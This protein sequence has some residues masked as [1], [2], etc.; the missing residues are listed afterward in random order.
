MLRC[1]ER[2]N[3]ATKWAVSAAVF[4]VVAYLQSPLSSWWLVGAI[5]NAAVTKILKKIFKQRRPVLARLDDE[6]TSNMYICTRFQFHIQCRS[7]VN[8][9]LSIGRHAIESRLVAGLLVFVCLCVAPAH[10]RFHSRHA[11]MVCARHLGRSARAGRTAC[12]SRLPHAG[13]SR[14]RM[15]TGRVDRRRV[16]SRRAAPG[17]RAGAAPAQFARNNYHVR[18]RICTDQRRKVALRV[19]QNARCTVNVHI[20]PNIAA[21]NLM[22][23]AC[24]SEARGTV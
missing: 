17:T 21:L 19:A 16:V 18:A 15:C 4:V 7:R 8:P 14:C 13:A 12:H 3:E 2:V 22:R 24:T 11:S 6:G 10:C 9:R 5:V 1:L 20:V 23:Q